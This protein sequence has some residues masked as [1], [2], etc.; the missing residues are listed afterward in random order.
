[1]PPAGRRRP[2]PV[3]LDS[4][5]TWLETELDGYAAAHPNPGR[6]ADHRLNRFEYGN[7]VR[8][9]LALEI[10]TEELLPADESDQGFDNIAEVL[11]M[12]PT[13]LGRYM[14]AARRISQLAVGDSTIGPVRGDLQPVA[15]AQAG[16]PH[17]RAPA[18]TA[19]AAARSSATTFRWT[20]STW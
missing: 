6:V 10:D 13:L 18:V 3:A 2:E 8:D 9:L 16:R 17:E 11:S 4:F 12:S 7:A 15:R 19:R 20:A 1:M 14:F 5:V